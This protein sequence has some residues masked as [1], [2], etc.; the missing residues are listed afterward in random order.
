MRSKR[1]RIDIDLAATGPDGLRGC[2]RP[3]IAVTEQGGK[4]GDHLVVDELT[5]SREPYRLL[6]ESESTDTQH[7][8]FYDI[9]SSDEPLDLVRAELIGLLESEPATQRIGVR[10]NGVLVGTATHASLSRTS[11]LA[12]G[13]GDGDG[14]SFPINSAEYRAITFEC[15]TKTC[16][17]RAYTSFFDER[18]I[19]TCAVHGT[20]MTRCDA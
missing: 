5:R 9:G 7:D 18:R 3:A 15:R 20:S 6:L 2:T 12:A 8:R 1:H 13:I 17:E 16:R 11:G 19:P 4:Q 14:L 10:V